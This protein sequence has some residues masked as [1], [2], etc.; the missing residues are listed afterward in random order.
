MREF[1]N[2]YIVKSSLAS[3][4]VWL[5]L[6]L[7]FILFLLLMLH[8]V[9]T[10][11][12]SQLPLCLIFSSKIYLCSIL[13]GSLLLRLRTMLWTSKKKERD[14]VQT[15]KCSV[16]KSLNLFSCAFPFQHL[17]LFS[18]KINCFYIIR[19]VWIQRLVLF[20]SFLKCNHSA[21]VFTF[22]DLSYSALHNWEDGT[23]MDK[24]GWEYENTPLLGT[25]EA[26]LDQG[27]TSLSC[28]FL[29]PYL[30]VSVIT[31]ANTA[32]RI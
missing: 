26:C 18:Q 25:L 30:V 22:L 10:I 27:S 5:G 31:G 21:H 14:I 3:G 9:S 11:I 28:C 13:N 2:G 29:S 1:L 8:F 19:K 32:T 17:F 16:H 15:K 12:F 6:V 4:L 7:I 24:I 20:S 23:E